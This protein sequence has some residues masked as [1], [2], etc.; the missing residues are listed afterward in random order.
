MRYNIFRI[1][2]FKGIHDLKIELNQ[3]PKSHVFTLVG[4]NESGK[5]TILEALHWLTNPDNYDNTSLI[6]RNKMWNFND[7]ISVSANISLTNHDE[8]MISAYSERQYK[9]ILFEKID[10]V[11]YS[12]EYLYEN[13]ELI[14]T[15]SSLQMKLIGKT[16]R[17][18]S[19]KTL[20]EDDEKYIKVSN[21]ILKYLLPPIIYYENFLFDFPDKIYLKEK[22]GHKLNY[23]DLFYFKVIQ[24]VMY[25]IDKKRELNPQKHL[26]DR[27]LS[28]KE[29]ER[30]SLGSTLDKLSSKIT[31]EVF[32]AWRELLKY[33]STALSITLGRTLEEDDKG[34]FIQIQ[35]KEGD[36]PYLIRER[37]LGFRW[38]FS[39]FLF[40]HFR[41]Y[42]EKYKKN[43]LYLLDEPASNLHQT[44]QSKILN[45]FDNFPNK[46][47][48]I[49]ATHSHHMVN[50]KWLASTFV[51]KN[52]AREYSDVDVAY[53][54]HKTNIK[55]ER[56]YKFVASYP[57]DQDYFRPILDALDYQPSK[58]E[59][60]PEIIMVEGKNDFYTLKYFKEMNLIKSSIG[61]NIY[62]GTGKDKI[63]YIVGLYIAWGKEFIVL[64]D[65][66]RGGKATKERLLKRYGPIIKNK[67]FIL[68]DIVKTWD[69][70]CMEDVFIK[71]DYP[72]II[73]IT[74]PNNPMYKKSK[75]N[76]AIQELY[77]NKHIIKLHT[78]TIRR[79]QKIFNFIEKKF[80][81]NQSFNEIR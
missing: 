62:P 16:K 10:K 23:E 33:T 70:F 43:G 7:T 17:M 35:V 68:S 51:V 8:R 15:K 73:K 79:F 67:I 71:T 22:N 57:N 53:D 44:A 18:K 2:N 60:V 61:D 52:E 38:F 66:D 27:Y 54:S 74:F 78:N 80:T 9:F 56:Y 29:S 41:A 49:Y 69:N 40:T 13:S 55:V 12:R 24:D 81:E 30:R 47:D 65:A 76:T 42:R 72:K 28:N 31:T 25:A 1:N 6:P 46:Q 32:T 5:T 34:Y 3:L 58:L 14:D 21:Y 77:I 37:S 11:K 75:F 48:I 26:V 39:F 36:N 19:I 64:L 20:S 63:E 45:A 4:L 59:L 50:P